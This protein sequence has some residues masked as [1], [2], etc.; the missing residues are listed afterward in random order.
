MEEG[1]LRRPYWRNWVGEARDDKTCGAI[2][3]E[4]E[5]MVLQRQ[6]RYGLGHFEEAAEALQRVEAAVEVWR[7]G[8]GTVTALGPGKSESAALDASQP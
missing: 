3:A 6:A 7:E 5:D 1:Y 8:D 4:S 2:I